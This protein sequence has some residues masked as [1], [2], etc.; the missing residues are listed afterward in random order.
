[1]HRIRAVLMTTVSVIKFAPIASAADIPAKA[2]PPVSIPLPV[3]NWT[4]FSVG[5]D[6]GDRN[7]A[8]TAGFVTPETVTSA[9]SDIQTVWARVNVGLTPFIRTY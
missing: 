7:Q 1:M 4:G 8:V 5:G 6:V 3:Y 9:P 2:P